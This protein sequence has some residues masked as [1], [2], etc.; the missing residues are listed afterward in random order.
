MSDTPGPRKHFEDSAAETGEHEEVDTADGIREAILRDLLVA[1]TKLAN[2][3]E[4][5]M[6]LGEQIKNASRCE[7]RDFCATPK[8]T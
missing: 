2:H 1:G 4:A 6:K 5:L 7:L 3:G 8:D